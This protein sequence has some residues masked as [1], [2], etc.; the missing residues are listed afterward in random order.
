MKFITT[1]RL[2]LAAAGLASLLLAGTASADYRVTAFGE[3]AEYSALLSK[4]VESAKSI[5]SKREIAKLD[6]ISANNLCV[7][8][9][10]AKEFSEAISSCATA[11][12][13]V[14]AELGIGVTTEKT[15]KASILSNLAVAKA[16][17]GDVSGASMDLERAL[18]LNSRDRNA[19]S[20]FNLISALPTVSADIAG[21]I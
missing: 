3:T 10:L 17:N 11:L 9:I 16:M 20:N 8:Q 4:D 19:V 15:A 14:D 6:F 5:F 7:T 12:E 21:N 18:L 13:K 1:S 2:T